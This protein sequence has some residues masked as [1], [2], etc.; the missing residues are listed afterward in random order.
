[1]VEDQGGDTRA[2]A[3]PKK[4]NVCFLRYSANRPFVPGL[5]AKILSPKSILLLLCRGRPVRL[6]F[7]NGA[8]AMAISTLGGCA[9]SHLNNNTVEIAS[10]ID[11][12]YTRQTLSNLSKF[13]DDAH[14]IPS[15]IQLNSGVFQT[16][17]TL[18]PT[19]TAPMS[20]QIA[21]QITRTATSLTDQRTNTLAGFGL[22][23]QGSVSQQQN[24]T[25]GPLNDANTLRNQR[26]LYTWAVY[27]E[28]LYKNYHPPKTIFYKNKFIYDPFFLQQPHCVLCIGDNQTYDPEA[29]PTI[30]QLKLNPALARGRWL[31]ADG[32]GAGR[33][34]MRDLGSFD[35]HELYMSQVDFDAGVLDDFVLFTLSFANPTVTISPPAK[36][37]APTVIHIDNFPPG[38]E[39]KLP[40]EE[41]PSEA[42]PSGRQPK[43]VPAPPASSG[44]PATNQMNS[45]SDR[46]QT[47]PSPILPPP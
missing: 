43:L 8:I 4:N 45:P 39:K 14:A 6:N 46:Q 10:R 40:Q 13:I 42:P 26:A 47:F 9:S 17:D 29:P 1:L 7:K 28:S 24:Y 30:N 44:A 35:N 16:T 32:D 2:P 5:C 20:S 37:P 31:F 38:A 22:S 34:G 23:V 41:K 18:Q 25:G 21:S 27:G 12:V 15:Q 36:S 33:A 3:R 11:S 19:V